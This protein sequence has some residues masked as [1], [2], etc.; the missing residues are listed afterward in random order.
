MKK[1]ILILVFLFPIFL[2]AQFI[3]EMDERKND[4]YFANS[5]L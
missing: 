5:I 1:L 2:N 3:V 4:I